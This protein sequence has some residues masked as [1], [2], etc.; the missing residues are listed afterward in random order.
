MNPLIKKLTLEEKARLLTGAT[1]MSTASVERLGIKSKNLA[2]GPHGVRHPIEENCT[3][4]PNLCNVGASWDVEN[5]YRFGQA[6]ADDCIYHDVDM[7]LAPGV[8]MKRFMLCG[9]NFEYFAE[10]PVLAGELAAAYINGAEDSGVATSL[11]HLAANSQEKYRHDIN[12]EIDER[13]LREIY[14]RAFEI[15]LEKSKPT[16]VMCAYNKLN[17]IWCS[18][19]RQLLTEILRD[20]WG[21]DGFVVSDWGAVQDICK[22]IRAGLDLEM[23][24]NDNIYE[25]LKEGLENG[26]ITMDDI[27]RAIDRLLKFIERPKPQ[28][29]PYDRNAQHAVAREIAAKGMV[30]LKNTENTL[31]LTE[32]KYKKIAVIGEY[33]RD[34]LI[35]GQGSAEVHPQRE[36]IDDPMAELEKLMPRTE[37]V[38]GEFYKKS[39]YSNKMIWP[40][41]KQLKEL[42]SDCDVVLMFV[43]SKQS[44]D[45]EKYDRRSALMDPNYDM[46]VGEA[47]KE[48]KKVVVICQSGSA[49][50]FENYTLDAHAIVQMWLS[51]ESAG[52]AIA[53][54]LTGKVNP[55]GKLSETFP[56][57]PRTDIDY[58]TNGIYTEYT[59]KLNVGYRY[60][61]RHPNEICFP[62]GHGL[63]YTTFEYSDLKI[64]KDNGWKVTFNIKNTGNVAGAEVVQLYIGD[65]ISIVP[66]PLKELKKF[67]KVKLLPNESTTVSFELD[68]RDLAYYNVSLHRFVAEDGKYNVFIGS[69]SRDIRLEGTLMHENLTDYTMRR[70]GEDMIG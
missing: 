67:A 64:T 17:A 11:K 51:G 45:T 1:K 56:T 48:G 16:S 14:L 60:Y 59:D 5:A 68:E 47:L 46:F 4:F 65:P 52:G 41:K 19:H 25:Q 63:S 58:P 32:E 38:Y 39:G 66:K 10:D 36:Y 7:I 50:L 27:D 62:F 35:S 26:K 54:V 57:K 3:N 61:D 29:K 22:A 20:E 43:G 53:D 8:N 37:F 9:R 18:E 2:D 24:P 13:T 28:K 55:E 33:G 30:L 44:D 69:S 6:I 49:M 21:Y 31:P 70:K 23:P 12:A 40:T 15:A 34:P 42:I